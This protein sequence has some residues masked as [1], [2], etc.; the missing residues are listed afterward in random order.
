VLSA[1]CVVKFATVSVP[2]ALVSILLGDRHPKLD[3]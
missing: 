1:L 2:L 3:M